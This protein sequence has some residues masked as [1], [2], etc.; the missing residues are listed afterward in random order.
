MPDEGLRRCTCG[1]FFLLK[2]MKAVEE[3]GV[4]E[5]EGLSSTMAVQDEQLPECFTSPV[6][7]EVEVAARLGYRRYLNHDYRGAYVEHRDAEDASTRMAWL[8]KNPDQRT[9]WDRLLRRPVHRYSR[10]EGSAFTYPPYE[11]SPEQLAN[12]ERLCE[13]LQQSGPVPHGHTLELLELYRAL[14]R[15][16]DARAVLQAMDPKDFGTPGRL[17]AQLIEEKERA[18]MRYAM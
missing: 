10:P 14:G 13:L 5:C 6:S 1:Q 12:M 7:A 17:I 4:A 9:W 16:D 8:A 15:F 11:P 3:G 2:D 18:P